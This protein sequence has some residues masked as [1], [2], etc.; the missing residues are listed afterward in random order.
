MKLS[1]RPF[2]TKSLP[3]DFEKMMWK[4]LEMAVHSIHKQE[5]AR[6][7][8]EELYTAVNDLCL[9]GFTD[10]L[11]DKLEKTCED[12]IKSV[13][14]KLEGKRLS[15]VKFL[16][17]L[18][19]VWEGTCIELT[20]IKTV[21]G[22]LD[23]TVV[24]HNSRKAL[25]D[26]GLAIFRTIFTNSESTKTRTLTALLEQ[27]QFERQGTSINQGLMKQTLSMM[28][29]LGIY[30]LFEAPFLQET[31]RFYS[32]EAATQLAK[33]GDIG[34]YLYLIQS[35][36]A[37]EG[38]KVEAYL[39]FHTRKQL[40]TDVL[41]CLIG[42]HAQDILDKGFVSLMENKKVAELRL[43]YSHF[44]LPGVQKVELL[45]N[46][47]RIFV[48]QAGAKK[49]LNEANDSS[50]ISDLL[51]FKTEL[52]DVLQNAFSGR[53]EL[54]YTLR[55]AFEEFINMRANRPAELLAKYIDSKMKPGAKE[56][57]EQLEPLLDQCLDL[58]RMIAAKDV[59]EAFY[60]KD[61]AKRLLLGKCASI[62]TEKVFIGKLKAE[63]GPSFTSKLEGMLKDMEVSREVLS[64]YSGEDTNL[65]VQILTESYW[66]TY[67]SCQ[68]LLPTKL[69][70]ALDG[71]KT[72]YLKKYSGRRLVWQT[73][74]CTC[75]VK[76][77]YARVK[78]ELNVSLMQAL[79]LL[80]FNNEKEVSFAKIKEL[81][82]TSDVELTRSLQ[83]LAFSNQARILKRTVKGGKEIADTD[84]FVV[85]EELQHRHYKIRVNGIQM[86]ETEDE[87][88]ATTE[89]VFQDRS[90]SIDACVVRT[91]KSRKTVCFLLFFFSLR[92]LFIC[93]SNPFP[94]TNQSDEP[95]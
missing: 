25:W 69:S 36:I 94:N 39:S 72:F 51:V 30:D 13:F 70:T 17:A 1:I 12:H 40:T 5:A 43:L 37:E 87:A 56:T 27:I 82:G 95:L 76:A 20:V 31:R 85:N 75:T 90:Y 38:N 71:V 50:M 66:P 11:Y 80:I 61:F 54:G 3:G 73:C 53:E 77:T 10:S 2:E 93:F 48:K 14:S 28:T 68:V 8:L 9:H 57:D 86:N 23:R 78:K 60:K 62:Y 35:R 55:D 34:P 74:L 33:E 47:F 81:V 29:S 16:S 63:C 19:E 59:F 4:K 84:M 22:S 15:G 46:S 79:I 24:L 32:E 26:M 6:H 64:E 91:M 65:S 49:V 88:K 44:D 21:F 52:D 18:S 7:P 58:F 83:A 92:S 45:K 67:Q 41:Q 42:D 89:R